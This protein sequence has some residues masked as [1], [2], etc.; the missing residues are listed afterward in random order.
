[1]SSIKE[2][3]ETFEQKERPVGTLLDAETLTAQLVAATRFY[4]G[5]AVIMARASDST[6]KIDENLDLSDSEYALIRP[7]FLL[8]VER[9]TAL[10]IEASRA[11]GVDTFGRSAAEVA[12]DIAQ[13]EDSMPRKAFFQPIVTV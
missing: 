2:L 10:Q 12:A 11:M 13:A 7:L 3:V 8:Y 4:A 6:V 1:M 5:F 9:E